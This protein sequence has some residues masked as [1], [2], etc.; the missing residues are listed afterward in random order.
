MKLLVL[1][2]GRKN[3]NTADAYLGRAKV[4]HISGSWDFVR[5]VASD[6]IEST[7]KQP[8]SCRRIK[9]A[10]DNS[11]FLHGGHQTVNREEPTG[12]DAD[13]NPFWTETGKYLRKPRG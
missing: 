2:S 6:I 10:A 12:Y 1:L 4:A 9:Q 11:A 8:P 13:G 3:R 7:K 5:S